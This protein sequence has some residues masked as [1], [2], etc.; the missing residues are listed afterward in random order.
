MACS[1]LTGSEAQ[2][3]LIPGDFM[4]VGGLPEFN[5]SI[6]VGED[7]VAYIDG[8]MP[9]DCACYKYAGGIDSVIESVLLGDY[10]AAQK[11]W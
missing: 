7:G 1:R 10:R 5:T 8:D 6:L 3:P 2:W 9:L 4:Q 11:I